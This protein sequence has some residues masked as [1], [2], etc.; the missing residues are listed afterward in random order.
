[1]MIMMMI[2]S[3]HEYCDA[4]DSGC[5]SF[6]FFFLFFLLLLFFLGGRGPPPTCC[7]KYPDN[8]GGDS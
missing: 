8:D 2:L 4:D 1:M 5:I 6:V 7:D 3:Q